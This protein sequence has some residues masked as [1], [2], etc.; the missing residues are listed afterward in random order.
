MMDRIRLIGLLILLSAGV[1]WAAGY[2]V[3]MGGDEQLCRQAAEAL[4]VGASPSRV[5]RPEDDRI[6]PVIWEPV[7]LGGEAPKTTVCSELQQALVDLNNDGRRDLVIRARFCMKGKPSDSL[8]VFPEDS[9]VLQEATWQDLTPLHATPDK[10]ERTGGVYPLSEGA[11]G[12][13]SAALHTLF[14]IEPFE[15]DGR[16]YVG[17]TSPPYDDV[18][19]ATYQAGD[20]FRDLCYLRRRQS[21]NR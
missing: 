4:E 1:A 11:G 17:L 7:Q 9:P 18:V 20:A 5:F 10:F 3:L 15:V 16:T 2:D 6:H 13:A 12:G 8:Y 19:I 21:S 14:T